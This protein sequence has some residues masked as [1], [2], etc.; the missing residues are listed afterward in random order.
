MIP[1]QRLAGNSAALAFL[2][3]NFAGPVSITELSKF[4]SKWVQAPDQ[5]TTKQVM[6][7]DPAN[8]TAG[9]TNGII[10]L[11]TTDPQTN[12][13]ILWLIDTQ[14]ENLLVYEYLGKRIALKALIDI[15]FDMAVPEGMYYPP[16]Q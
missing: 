10:A 4:P 2:Q 9:Q 8:I 15:Q 16:L 1:P 7:L 5:R 11:T 6:A 3:K 12:N 14:R 13:S